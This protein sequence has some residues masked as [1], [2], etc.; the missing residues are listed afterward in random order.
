M[1]I[2][3]TNE[4]KV[5]VILAPLTEAGNPAQIDGAPVWEV[6]EGDATLEVA[7]DG[8]SAYLVSGEANINSKI[9]V[10]ADADLGDGISELS[11][12]IDL[13]VVPAT[14]SLLGLSVGTPVLK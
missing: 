3:I 5:E 1:L 4:Q 2:T 14:A 6:I 9:K 11:D 8:M 13:A 10:T 12:I 7:A